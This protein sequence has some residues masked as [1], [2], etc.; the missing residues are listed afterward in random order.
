M[1]KYAISAILA[2]CFWGCTGLFTRT[3]GALGLSSLEMLAIRCGVAAICFCLVIVLKDPK[4]LKVHKKDIWL[5][6]AVGIAGQFLFSFFYYTAISMMSI[7]TACILMYLSPA[8]VMIMAHFIFKDNVGR[9]GVFSVVL[10]VLGCACVSGFGGT[11]S[12]K[13]LLFGLGSAI[14]FALINIFD[15]MLLKR[16][17][18]SQTVNFYL[19]LI[20]AL[21]AILLCG[22][23]TS[24]SVMTGSVSNFLL[25]VVWG[26]FTGFLPYL[27]FSHA[28]SHCESGVVSV[29]ASTEP[30]AAS[31]ISV[32]LFHEPFGILNFVGIVLVLVGIVLQNIQIKR[33]TAE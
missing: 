1:N 12:A 5:F 13:G 18:D 20:A 29:L 17:Y 4:R 7:S 28:L 10:C 30:V 33:H 31:L 25:C 27:F 6:L 3:L 16:G 23:D 26:I 19:C 9:Q 22:V 15:R 11:V 32:V 21:S 24:I 8:L 2:G 14:C